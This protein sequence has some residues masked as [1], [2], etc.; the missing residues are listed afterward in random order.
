[1]ADEPKDKAGPESPRKFNEP[2]Y[3]HRDRKLSPKGKQQERDSIR[4][5]AGHVIEMWDSDEG[6]C[7]HIAARSGQG[8]TFGPKGDIKMTS[9]NGMYSIVF[10]ENR[11][12]ITGTQDITVRGGGTLKVDGD[13]DCTIGGNMN[14]TVDNDMNFKGFGG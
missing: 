7:M 4:T 5:P 14:F 3:Y 11:M 1:M 9:H 2:D 13:Y 12:E 8:F 6:P 10:G